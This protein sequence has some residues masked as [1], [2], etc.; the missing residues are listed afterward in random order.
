VSPETHLTGV[1]PIFPVGD[2]QRALAHYQA[3]G[4]VTHAYEGAGDYGYADRDGIS[5][6]LAGRHHEEPGGEGS[7]AYLFVDDADALYAEW[8]R[9]GIGGITRHVRDT[10]YELREGAH[11]DLDGNVIRFGSPLPGR[12]QARLHEHLETRYGI[13]VLSL[14]ELD[15]GVFRV[16]RR[17]G[18]GWIARLFPAV[19]SVEAVAGDAEVLRFLAEHDFP[20]ERTA[21]TEPL[22]VLDGQAVLATEYVDP[23]PRA[24]R[25]AAIRDAGGLRRLGELLGRLHI[26]PEGPG[27]L[28]RPGGA[29]HHLA[30]GGPRAEID[31]AGALLARADGL[32]AAAQRPLYDAL[33]AEL[34]TLDDGAG[35]PQ[36][37]VHPDFVLAN[38]VAS[39]GQGMVLVDWAGTGRAP[40]VW[41]LAWLLFAE[42][43]RD[44]RRVD[45]IVGGYRQH[46]DLEPEELS[47]LEAVARVRWVILKSWEFCMG[48]RTLDDT[49][50]EIADAHALAAA[51]G[52]RARA[53]FASTGTT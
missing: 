9:P 30:D 18:S 49:T 27:A 20:A 43:A 28:T 31:A 7:E 24:Q 35:L 22:S 11:I 6:H 34:D 39:P 5:L 25:R 3:L 32:A 36:A 26:L 12:G 17:H 21:T 53:A 41:S 14:S 51:V 13:E 19:R 29:W 47:R 10:P 33:R 37:L 50:R 15:A 52:S 46:V 16:E 4:F 38:V 42:G 1:S 40:R 23:V 2:M 44:L 45:L 8:T 48:H